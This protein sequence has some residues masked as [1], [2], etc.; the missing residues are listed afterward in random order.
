[1][2]SYAQNCEDVMLER[3]FSGNDGGFYIDVGAWEP[4]SDSVTKHFYDKGWHGINVEPMPACHAKLQEQRTRD[5]NLNIALLDKAG[6]TPFYAIEGTGL[7]TVKRDY[8][9]SYR[10]T[11]SDVQEHVFEASTLSAI[12]AEYVG[13]RLIDFLKVD[14]EGTELQVLEG[15]DWTR[16]RPRVVLI[17]AT[18]PMSTSPSF[19]ETE[20]FML[21]HGY[22]FAYFDGLNRF[23]VATEESD[24]LKHFATPPN[25][26]DSF[27]TFRTVNAEARINEL[28]RRIDELE[29]RL[30]SAMKKAD[31]YDKFR[32]SPVGRVLGRFM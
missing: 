23:Y 19:A 30:R 28:A 9:E 32:G 15:G 11:G 5:V 6:N 25:V 21:A 14:T 13:D 3:A 17:E 10:S 7:S 18:I 29:A 8:A 20:H 31:K 16:F 1:M 27:V 26:F 22:L 12:C 4:V 2:V 24:L